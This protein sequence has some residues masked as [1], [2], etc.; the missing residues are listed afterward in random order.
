MKR[1]VILLFFCG[2]LIVAAAVCPVEWF[3][4]NRAPAHWADETV[5]QLEELGVPMPWKRSQWDEPVLR[6][7]FC[8]LC[9][10]VFSP[11]EGGDEEPYFTDVPR[12]HPAYSSIQ[13][14]CRSGW[15]ARGEQFRPDDPLTRRE[16]LLLCDRLTPLEKE[17]PLA[18]PATD[19][20]EE[21]QQLAASAVQSG[22]FNYYED[23]TFRPDEPVTKAGAAA[24]VCRILTAQK[25]GD[26]IRR[27]MLLDYLH[28]WERGED[29]TPLC[30]GEE[31]ERQQFRRDRV[32]PF[33]A[34]QRPA[35]QLRDLTLLL[36][37]QGAEAKGTVI[38]G[39]EE[40]QFQA[41][42]STVCQEEQWKVSDC[43]MQFVRSEP[44]RMVWEYTSRPGA[45]YVHEN[46]ANLV[47]PTWF[48]LID[49][50]ETELTE[51]DSLITDT[52]YLSDYYSAP[53]QKEAKKRGQ[54]IWALCS[55]GF[56]PERTRQVL[57]DDVLRQTLEEAIFSKAIA[58]GLEGINLDFENMYRED[59]DLFTRFVQ[60][61]NFYSREWGIFLS[62]DITKIEPSSN[63]YSMCYDRQALSRY[64][65]YLMLM[66]YDQ[67][68][69]GS[70]TA[71][72]IAALNWTE[73]GLDGVL[74][75]V[76]AEKLVLGI[77]FYTRI[78]KTKDSM[79][80][81]AP[82][83]SMQ[84]V[85]E[86]IR[87]KKLT[88][89]WNEE[90][91][92]NYVEFAEDDLLCRIWIEDEQSISARLTLAEERGLAGVAGWSGG[93]ETPDLW[94]LLHSRLK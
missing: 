35:K 22:L 82:A 27:A 41:R 61:C 74:Q 63:F 86:L 73:E 66:A 92:L 91:Q 81:E 67:H 94:E 71:G 28:R 51:G 3:L 48:K 14:A 75:E 54:E 78:W 15:I 11:A 57:S 44:I 64:T 93:Y 18:H 34:E 36:T 39:K 87:K 43:S 30:V 26:A 25:S 17:E 4:W 89:V 7:E 40:R 62:A 38:F 29:V 21:L 13:A 49:E 42:W 23:G 24:V 53:F 56:T 37:P 46:Q 8:V 84:E 59:R 83:A 47:S 88:K 79:V 50:Q 16:L 80:Q 52:V 20:P 32:L 77:P 12:E 31:A 60:E 6:G 1:A 72:P 90:E 69:A 65:D 33:Q 68:P 9:G 70:K 5:K 10:S 85:E 58:Y 45:Q 55:N 2:M 19:L 76:P